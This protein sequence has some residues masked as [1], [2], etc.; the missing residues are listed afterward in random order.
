MNENFLDRLSNAWNAFFNRDPTNF[1]RESNGSSGGW[2]SGNPG[3]ARFST[4]TERT[5]TN[6][7]Y[8]RIALDVAAITIRHVRLD[9][10]NR[11]I[12]TMDSSLN[13]RLSLD[14]NKDQPSRSFIQDAVMTMIDEGC[15]A[16]VPIDSDTDIDT[17]SNYKILSM[18]VGSILEWFPDY[19]K[20]R[21][22]NDI[23]GI[24]EDIIVPKSKTCIIQNPL[25]SVINEPNSTMRRLTS[26]LNLLDI[27]DENSVSD[28]LNMIIQLPYAI[29]S[30]TSRERADSRKKALEDQLVNSKYGIGYIDGTEK[31]TQL[32]RPLENNL[33]SQV[34][35]LTSMLY[36]QLGMT[37]EILNGSAD[38]QSM[39]NYYSRTIEPIISAITDEMKIKFLTKTARSQKQSIMFFRDPF[40]LVPVN[41]IAEIADKFT[42]NEIMT[43]NEIRQ[44]VGMMPSDDPAADELR[45]KNLSQSKDAIAAKQNLTKN[46]EDTQ[47]E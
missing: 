18:R 26:K 37:N 46:K 43:S 9:E 3:R 25:Y 20:V 29:K 1:Y 39:L 45:N 8:N 14:A 33:L 36:S 17:H 28:K 19:V 35:Y 32:S 13:D 5:I 47:N 30:E 23:K 2:Y 44:I 24:K 40:K 31:I 11:Y 34:E 41:D 4:T 27:I 15:V 16:L 22:Y 21:A 38:E 10:N 7:I 12:S 42:R 6:S